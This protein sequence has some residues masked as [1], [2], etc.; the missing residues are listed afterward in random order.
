MEEE[1]GDNMQG[2]EEEEEGAEDDEAVEENAADALTQ[3]E[4]ANISYGH[5]SN[6]EA[7]IK[8]I[9]NIRG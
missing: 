5:N 2:E 1:G 7:G 4:R 8:V 3:Q 9:L 6:K